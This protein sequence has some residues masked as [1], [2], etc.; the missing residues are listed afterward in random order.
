M[1]NL[2]LIGLVISSTATFAREVTVQVPACYET[3]F[4]SLQGALA[5][6]QAEAQTVCGNFNSI[7]EAFLTHTHVS[8]DS[9]CGGFTITAQYECRPVSTLNQQE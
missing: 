4:Q 1:K 2:F 9:G 5:R 3:Q 8:Q 6:A 7:R